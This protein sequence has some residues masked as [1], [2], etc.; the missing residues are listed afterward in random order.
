MALTI[1][2]PSPT[3]PLTKGEGKDGGQS[4]VIGLEL[5]ETFP[6]VRSGQ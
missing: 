1:F 4:P 3:L 6:Q 5:A 2:T